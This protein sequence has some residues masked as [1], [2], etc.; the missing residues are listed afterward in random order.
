VDLETPGEV[1]QEDVLRRAGGQLPSR[2]RLVL[3][4]AVGV[5]VA[6]L[7]GISAWL[8]TRASARPGGPTGAAAPTGAVGATGAN[9]TT[10]A[11]GGTG[12]EGATGGDGPT[13]GVGPT[14]PSCAKVKVD[15]GERIT[16]DELRAQAPYI[17]LP[18]SDLANDGNVV[19][20]WDTD[21]EGYTVRYP[22]SI[23][24]YWMPAANVGCSVYP[25]PELRTI[26]GVMTIVDKGVEI[27]G[28][29]SLC[30]P[31]GVQGFV[32][33]SGHVPVSTLVE[34]AGTLSPSPNS[35]SPDGD[36]PPA[37]PPSGSSA[38]DTFIYGGTFTDGVSRK[39]VDDASRSLAFQPVAPSSLGDP[40]Q[41]LE[42]NSASAAPS[43]RELSLRYDDAAHG[44]LFWLLERPSSSMSAARLKEI[45]DYCTPTGDPKDWPPC[46]NGATVDL[47][48]GVSGIQIEAYMT[49]K[50]VWV[51]GGVFF[52]VVGS[53][54][55]ANPDTLWPE[56]A[57]PV[58]KAVAAAAGG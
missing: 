50:T 25:K 47:G 44:R 49:D 30:L 42:T 58:A 1:D 14:C 9:G 56:R 41:I 18:K 52:E 21:G 12:D 11:V 20:I 16:F 48:G 54:G 5:V 4:L 13:G 57:L 39:S 28:V 40:S 33:L 3:A 2:R 22:G 19:R 29:Q 10:G 51:E 45:A 46:D 7:A 36:L 8:A 32:V 53:E 26:D 6:L 23:R 38:W 43:D 17:P 55:D 31:V 27:P 34:I 15:Y 37:T 24:L 35:A